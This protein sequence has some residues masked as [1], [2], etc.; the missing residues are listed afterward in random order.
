MG[1]FDDDEHAGAVCEHL[2]QWLSCGKGNV[3][4]FQGDYLFN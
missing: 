4:A 3:E 1:E 2:F